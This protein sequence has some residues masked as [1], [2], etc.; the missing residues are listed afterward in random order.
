MTLLQFSLLC[1]VILFIL[2]VEA[3]FRLGRESVANKTFDKKIDE[4]SEL[5]RKD[6][7]Q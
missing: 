7:R 6:L 4:L 2:F 5:N 3:Q 1:N